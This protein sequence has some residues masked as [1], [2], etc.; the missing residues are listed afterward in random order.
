MRPNILL[1]VSDDCT[2]IDLPLYGGR[3]AKTPHIDR[4]AAEGLVFGRAYLSMA[5]CQPCRAELYTGLYPMRNGCAWNH[6][7]SRPEVTGMP[8]HLGALGY[9]VGI[10]GKIHVEPA[11]AYPFELVEGFDRNCVR[12]PTLPHDVAGLREFMGRNDDPFC[13]VVGLVDP[14]V[15]WVMGDA[16]PFPPDRLVLPPNLADTAR[17]REDFSR[18]LAEI[19]YMDGQVGDIMAAL[20]AT[21]RAGNTLVI[22]T[23]EQGSQF[24]GAKWTCWN[25]GLHT[26]VVAR[27]PGRIAAGRRTDALI[28]YADM[29]PTLVEA[30]GGDPSAHDYDGM[31]FLDVL[32]G[33]A[34][35]SRRRF[36]YG[37]HNNIP[38]GPPYPIRTVSDGRHRYIRNLTPD[39]LYLER[40]M[41]GRRVDGAEHCPY[42]QTWVWDAGDHPPVYRRVKRYLLRPA[43]ELYDS[44]RD[45]YELENLAGDKVHAE[46]MARLRAELD[47]WMTGQGDPG[48]PLDT[49][50]AHH[51]A[52]QGRHLYGTAGGNAQH[53]P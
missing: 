9:R 1:I 13:L 38:E 23:S 15:P 17:T 33:D 50:E 29:L 34:E 51:A 27:W 8:Q 52:K 46:T 11:A 19:A 39:E 16:S 42:W 26:G 31:S 49:A 10:A 25:L 53:A 21:G 22:F 20:E 36:V 44:V 48:I 45:P 18:Y 37:M 47:R 30:A 14:H 3:N 7:A 43:E 41:M 4:L 6:S 35:A 28:Q 40:H 2:Y 24:P 5:M 32:T 12:H